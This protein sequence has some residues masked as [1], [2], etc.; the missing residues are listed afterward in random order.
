MG[1]DM[2]HLEVTASCDMD[3]WSHYDSVLMPVSSMGVS[4]E[5]IGSLPKTGNSTSFPLYIGGLEEEER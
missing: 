2:D 4:F 1:L 5:G 3:V